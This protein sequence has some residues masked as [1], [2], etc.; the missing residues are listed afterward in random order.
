MPE[1]TD[2]PELTGLY[3]RLFNEIGI[4]SQLSR[5]MFEAR[6]PDGLVLP[7]FTVINHLIR[8][9]DGQTPLQ[10]ARAFQVPKTS[11]THTLAGLEK[12]G[13]VEMRA[14]PEDARSKQVWLTDAGRRFRDDA[15]AGMAPDVA[16]IADTLPM[17]VVREITD[18]LEAL[19]IRLDAARV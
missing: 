16:G 14:N 10:V 6:L 4:I 17:D 13:L 2:T 5:A 11:M 15:I 1:T 9:K 18:H 7:H 8:V 12:R 19:R 3:F